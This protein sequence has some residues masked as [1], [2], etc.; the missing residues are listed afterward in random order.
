VDEVGERDG[1][2]DGI[3]AADLDEIAW[4]DFVIGWVEEQRDIAPLER[5][6]L[7][8]TVALLRYWRLHAAGAP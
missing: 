5:E 1:A 2:A 8:T 7:A 6:H 3:D 4:L